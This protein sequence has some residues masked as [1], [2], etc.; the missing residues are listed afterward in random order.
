M[1]SIALDSVRLVVESE[2]PALH[3]HYLKHA[4]RV[5]SFDLKSEG[6][7]LFVAASI[8]DSGWPQLVVQQRY[9]PGPRSGFHPGLCVIPENGLLFIGA[10]TRLLAYSLSSLDKL[11]EDVTACGF[12]GWARHDNYVVMSAELEL[13]VW[14]LRGE[15]CW[16]TF[17]EPPWTYS[18]R[19]DTVELDV[20]GTKSS[21]PLATGP[22]H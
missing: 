1:I 9:D 21:F 8:G 15:R 19:N 17:V 13:A 12:W 16:A 4:K 11:W 5:E 18:V 3:D 6:E 2:I 7:F 10:G 20:M 14:S 22:Q